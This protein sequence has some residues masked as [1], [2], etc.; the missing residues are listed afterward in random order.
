[1][2]ALTDAQRELHITDLG[3]QMQAAMKRA[4]ASHN[5]N[6]KIEARRLL[7]L[8]SKAIS[9]RSTE[10]VKAMEIER[11]LDEG[12]YFHEMGKRRAAEINMGASN[13]R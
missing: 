7:D 4:E 11:G 10:Q 13:V 9:E 6:D 2:N 3:H 8:Q 12:C 1:M 5:A